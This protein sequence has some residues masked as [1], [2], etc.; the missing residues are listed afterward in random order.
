MIIVLT[1]PNSLTK[2]VLVFPVVIPE[3]KFCDVKRQVF[4]ADLGS[5]LLAIPTHH[6]YGAGDQL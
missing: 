6:R 3:L 4:G 5:V 1:S 2:D